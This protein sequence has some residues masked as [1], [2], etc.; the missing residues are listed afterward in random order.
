VK[1]NK[2]TLTN[3][4]KNGS[5]LSQPRYDAASVVWNNTTL[6][7]TGGHLDTGKTKSTEFVQLTGTTPGPDLPL[8][9]SRHCLVSLNDTTLLLIGGILK[10]G[11]YSKATFFYNT[12]HNTWTEGPS[13]IIG[14]YE[15]S[16]ALFK[17]PKHDHND[18]VIVTGG[19]NNVDGSLTSTKLL[20]LDSNSWQSGKGQ[21]N[22]P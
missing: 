12:D 16:C 14:R 19:F 1:T 7:L 4:I 10:E 13:L 2:Q 22:Y 3:G 21:L 20:N 8:K 6:W 11:T 15:H 5:R 17:S 18:T 9:V